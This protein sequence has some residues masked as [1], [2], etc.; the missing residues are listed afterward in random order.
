MAKIRKQVEANLEL[1][2]GL[3]GLQFEYLKERQALALAKGRENLVRSLTKM[4]EKLLGSSALTNIDFASYVRNLI[5]RLC[6]SYQVDTNRL[7]FNLKIED[8]F[9]GIKTA[10]PCGLII[11]ELVTNALKHA[12]P[13]GARGRITV[14]FYTEESKKYCLIVSHNGRR[15]PQQQN[16]PEAMATALQIVSDLVAQLRGELKLDR[17][18]GMK[19]KIS[20]PQEES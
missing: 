17:R 7:V 6:D 18:G 1:I 12:F 15:F 13:N 16:L 8:I 20:F 4:Q 11:S 14:E 19:F 2:Y 3:L 9:L 5:E 10:I